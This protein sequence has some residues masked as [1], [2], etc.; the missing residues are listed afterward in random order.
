[1][2]RVGSCVSRWGWRWMA[3][4]WAA[5]GEATFREWPHPSCVTRNGH[6]EPCA[7]RFWLIRQHCSKRRCGQL[8]TE[9]Q[10][11]ASHEHTGE[12]Q[13]AA[14]LRRVH[15]EGS[16]CPGQSGCDT[17]LTHMGHLGGG[18]HLH[19]AVYSVGGLQGLGVGWTTRAVHVSTARCV[20]EHI[21]PPATERILPSGGEKC[22]GIALVFRRAIPHCAILN[23]VTPADTNAAG[24]ECCFHSDTL[25]VRRF[26]RARSLGRTAIYVGFG[27]TA[28]A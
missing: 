27:N 5:T 13:G 6:Y 21:A 15:T 3:G 20:G 28:I 16:G 26:C 11:A 9:G 4:G 25:N 23:A 8:S 17:G 1:M 19:E 24:T 10:T 18:E 7:P 2:L 12:Q 22:R 14:R